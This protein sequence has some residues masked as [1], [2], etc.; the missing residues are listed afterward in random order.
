MKIW[1]SVDLSQFWKKNRTSN[2]VI[3][4]HRHPNLWFKA[5][6]ISTLQTIFEGKIQDF[7]DVK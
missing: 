6:K 3:P 4:W 2:D 7:D 5:N 1:D